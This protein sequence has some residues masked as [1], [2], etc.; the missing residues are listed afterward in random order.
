MEGTGKKSGA[1]MNARQRRDQILRRILDQGQVQVSDLMS[2]Y[3]VTDTSIRRDL[4]LLEMQGHIKRIHGGAIS[5]ARGMQVANFEEKIHARGDE[6]QRICA[7]AA[8]LIHPDD[9]VILDSGTTVLRLARNIPDPMRQAAALR[10][11][12]NSIPLVQEVGI[13]G[14]PNL[15]LLGGIYLPEYQATVGPEALQRLR[16][17][18]ANRAFLG[19]DGWT[20]DGGITTAHPLIAEVGRAMAAR[21]EQVVVLADSSKMGR[22]GFVSI[23][24][25]EAIDVL[26]TDKDLRPEHVEAFESRGVE[27]ISV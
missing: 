21:A 17:L 18:S 8:R 2:D 12:T 20:A 23:I 13:W 27:V 1:L 5:T 19:C 4:T 6:K 22:A 25:T 3:G 16:E 26:I 14:A 10:M 24:P 7:R 9:V 11:V 15:L